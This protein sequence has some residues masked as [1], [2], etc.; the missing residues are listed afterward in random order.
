MWSREDF[1]LGKQLASVGKTSWA[2]HT[3]SFLPRECWAHGCSDPQLSPLVC[4][5]LGPWSGTCRLAL[6]C[7]HS[8]ESA[9]PWQ[10]CLYRLGPGVIS[11]CPP[12]SG[13]LTKEHK[14][15]FICDCLEYRWDQ[16]VSVIQWHYWGTGTVQGSLHLLPLMKC[17]QLAQEVGIITPIL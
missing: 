7:S 13:S 8:L 10:I 15:S 6:L 9:P 2:W 11:L 14:D 17:S 3:G 12:Q 1:L 4:S 16:A 5:V